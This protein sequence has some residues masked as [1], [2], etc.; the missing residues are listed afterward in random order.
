MFLKS[1]LQE[2]RY[3]YIAKEKFLMINLSRNYF[4]SLLCIT[5]HFLL[6]RNDT[7]YCEL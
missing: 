5:N 3:V 2:E 6:E 1:Q 4:F 7:E